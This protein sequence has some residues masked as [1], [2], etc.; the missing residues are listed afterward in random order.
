MLQNHGGISEEWSILDSGLTD[1]VFKTC[2]FLKEIIAYSKEESLYLMSNGG[3]VME[4]YLKLE[5]KLFPLS[6]FYNKHL[7]A[8]IISL[9]DLI[10]T[11]GVTISMDNTN[12]YGF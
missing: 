1:T 11:S 3:E 7:L 10:Q 5:M 4:Y 6:V 2:R 9:F 12:A 8:N